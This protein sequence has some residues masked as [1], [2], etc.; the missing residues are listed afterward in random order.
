MAEHKV[1]RFALPTINARDSL[2]RVAFA[3]SFLV[4]VTSLVDLFVN[5]LLFRA[6]PSV[7]SAIQVPGVYYMAVVG[8]ISFNFEQLVLYVIL[9]CAAVSSFGGAAPLRGA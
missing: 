4:L 9:G 2:G 7:L 8:A 6:G 3:L 5:R 1:G